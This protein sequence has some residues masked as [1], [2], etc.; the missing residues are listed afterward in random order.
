[1]KSMGMT[2]ANM[3]KKAASEERNEPKKEK[4][5]EKGNPSK[6]KKE[7]VHRSAKGKC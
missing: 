3:I 6:E 1:M 5:M 4:M 2:L 7:K